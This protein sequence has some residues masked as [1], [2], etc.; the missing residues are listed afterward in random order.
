MD[1]RKPRSWPS[2]GAEPDFRALEATRRLEDVTRLISDWVWETDRELRITFVSERIFDQL[3]ILPAQMVGGELT[4]IGSFLDERGLPMEMDIRRPFRDVPFRAIG[5]T[6]VERSF[7]VA[8]VPCFDTDTGEFVGVH[9]IARDVTDLRAAETRSQRLSEAV[10]TLSEHFA[11]YDGNDRLVLCNERFRDLNRV[12]AETLRPGVP[13]ED[14]VRAAVARRLLP[15]ALGQEETWIQDRL[16]RHANPGGPFEIERSGDRWLFV[17]EKRLPD[18]GTVTMGMD[19]TAMKTAETELKRSE[20]RHR[21]FAADVAHELRT[22]LA[23]LRANLDNLDDDVA[24]ES[25]R[26]DVDVMSRMVEQLLTHTRL[27]TFVITPGETADL[28]AVGTRVAQ[29]MAPIALREGRSI[30]VEGGEG[31]AVHVQGEAAILEQAIRNL[32]EN[33]I[34][35][36]ARGTVITVRVS[37]EDPPGISIIDCGRGVPE[38]QREAIFERFRR[39]DRRAG[40]AGLGLGIVKRIVDAHDGTIA[41]SDNPEGGAVFTLSF[42][43][44]AG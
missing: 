19:I 40:G 4:D 18:G 6:G 20:Q 17:T 22:P 13:F 8:A 39:V 26:Q 11:L 43:Q 12:V 29:Q 36:S 16:V 24:A 23:V 3:S 32:L 37:N 25:L 9:G 30:E 28:V 7:L 34:K 21:E 5:R 35:Y 31:G 14:F 38:D 2:F 33:A 15:D 44:F 27:D 41:V 10:E 1:N 42:P